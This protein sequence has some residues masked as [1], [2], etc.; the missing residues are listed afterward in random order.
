MIVKPYMLYTS[1]TVTAIIVLI[2]VYLYL[3]NILVTSKGKYSV[4][5]AGRSVT[6]QWFKR[7]RLPSVLNNISIWREW[8]IPYN[9]HQEGDVYY[10]RIAIPSPQKNRKKQD[11]LYG[12]ETYKTLKEVIKSSKFDALF[13]KFCFVDFGDNSIKDQE[14]EE[15]RFLNMTDLVR[16]IHTLTK[17]KNMKMILGNALPTLTPGEYGQELRLRYNHWAKDYTNK[18][19][20]MILMD[21]Y[22]TLSDKNGQLNKKYSLD[23]SD[24]DSHL[25]QD[26]YTLLEN[27]LS[28]KIRELQ[29]VN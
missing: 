20:D 8:P 24:M 12:Q 22:G 9:K 18:N 11:Y 19:E 26:A 16:K 13:Y 2:A 7:R 29:H 23:L 27:E 15:Q 25:N 21:L 1:V 17:M 6:Q 10:E 28:I 14:S 4:A 3:P 5:M